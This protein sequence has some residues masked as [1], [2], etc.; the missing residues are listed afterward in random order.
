MRT[1]R[2]YRRAG[3]GGAARLS[4]LLALAGIL[5]VVAVAVLEVWSTPP[6]WLPPA[7]QQTVGVLHW[8]KQNWLSTAA[9]STAAGVV[10]V[11]TPFFFGGWTVAALRWRPG[12]RRTP[13]S[14]GR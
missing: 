6:G 11:L 8:S 13:N 12:R 10:G 14:S 4:W 1:T 7:R 5:L 3:E 2:T 9:L